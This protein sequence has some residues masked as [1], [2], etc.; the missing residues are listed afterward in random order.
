[1]VIRLRYNASCIASLTSIPASGLGRRSFP[2]HSALAAVGA[3]IGMTKSG[4]NTVLKS[5]R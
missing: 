2:T 4:D 1:M 3:F 5:S